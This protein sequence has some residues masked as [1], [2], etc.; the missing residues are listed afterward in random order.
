MP[1]GFLCWAAWLAGTSWAGI[2][3]AQMESFSAVAAMA[4]GGVAA[5]TTAVLLRRRRSAERR[6]PAWIG[7]LAVALCA[8][9]LPAIDTTLLSQDASIHRAAGRW[10]ARNGSLAIPDPTLEALDG[11]ERLILFS[12]GSMSDKRTSLVRV[13]GGVVIPSLD[14]TVAYPSF[15]HLLSVWVALAYSVAGEAGLRWLGVL[16]AFTAW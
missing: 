7:A 10:L 6:A 15:S 11:H 2:T 1:R 14:Q 12:G 9:L 3:L 13:P 8:T 4:G 5:A 16:F